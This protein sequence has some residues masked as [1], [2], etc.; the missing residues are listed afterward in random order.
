M[1][2][3]GGVPIALGAR[4]AGPG[5]GYDRRAVDGAEWVDVA[6]PGAPALGAVAS[7]GLW[8]GRGWPVEVLGRARLHHIV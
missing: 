3:Q 5:H 8:G 2:S 7:G 1:Q 4:R 6:A